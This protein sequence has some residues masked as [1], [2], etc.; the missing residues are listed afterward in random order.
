MSKG[1][2]GAFCISPIVSKLISLALILGK[3]AALELQ[4]QNH[5]SAA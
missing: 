5:L 3:S 2:S 1:P 4:I